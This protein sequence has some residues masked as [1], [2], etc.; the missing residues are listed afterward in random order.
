MKI[1]I[2]TTDNYTEMQTKQKLHNNMGQMVYRND[3]H[4]LYINGI[5]SKRL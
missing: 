5:I 3:F 4:M 2:K 1:C